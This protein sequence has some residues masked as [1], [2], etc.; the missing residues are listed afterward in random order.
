MRVDSLC[1][2]V[3]CLDPSGSGAAAG[4]GAASL[5]MK[6]PLSSPKDGSL[7]LRKWEAAELQNA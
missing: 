2:L 6:T 5:G 3:R 1:R 4:S 7:V